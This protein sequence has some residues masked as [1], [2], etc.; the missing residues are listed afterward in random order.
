MKPLGIT[1]SYGGIPMIVSIR[2]S[3][4]EKELVNSYAKSHGWSISEAIKRAIFE[5]IEDEYDIA[6]ADKALEEYRKHPEDVISHEDL[7]KKYGLL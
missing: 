1:M 6:I 7:M 2:M 3:E 5:A 4:K